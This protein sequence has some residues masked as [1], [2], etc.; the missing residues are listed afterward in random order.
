[1]PRNITFKFTYNDSLG[2]GKYSKIGFNGTCS[3]K[4]VKYNIEA[5]RSWFNNSSCKQYYEKRFKER[6]PTKPCYESNIFTNWEYDA[7]WSHNGIN[8]IVPII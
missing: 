6:K 4:I 8:G 3:D 1:M 7:G 2:N 5:G